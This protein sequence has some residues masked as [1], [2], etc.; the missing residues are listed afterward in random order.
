MSTQVLWSTDLS[1]WL[2]DGPL[3][4]DSESRS[5]RSRRL[6]LTEAHPRLTEEALERFL[7]LCTEPYPFQY[8]KSETGSLHTCLTIGNEAQ[9]V[10]LHPIPYHMQG[11]TPKTHFKPKS[12]QNSLKPQIN[13]QDNMY[14]MQQHNKCL[15]PPNVSISCRD[16][17]IHITPYHIQAKKEGK[18]NNGYEYQAITS[19]LT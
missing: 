6:W 3:V 16:S 11:Y 13:D 9:R 18:C 7:T 12:G 2:T 19:R 4:T 15:I 5:G 10:Y 14:T 17:S 1:L 8:I